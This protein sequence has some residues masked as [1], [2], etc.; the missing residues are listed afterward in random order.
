MKDNEQRV[1][2]TGFEKFFVKEWLNWDDTD[3]GMVFYDCVLDPVFAIIVG[4][5]H[6]D[7]VQ[8]DWTKCKIYVYK[9]DPTAPCYENDF[10]M[11]VGK[12]S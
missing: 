10:T 5:Q 6:A 4:H 11:S 3:L 9:N 2:A 12:E 1:T 8:I 7:E